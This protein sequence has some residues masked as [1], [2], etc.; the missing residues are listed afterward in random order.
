MEQ[1]NDA[2]R[3]RSAVGRAAAELASFGLSD[4]TAGAMR[5]AW[6]RF[7]AFSCAG[8]D[9]G[10]VADISAEVASAYVRARSEGGS[11]PSVAAMHWR[12]SA[13]RLLFR[14]W[15][16][17]GVCD[18]DPTLDLRLPRRSSLAARPLADDEVAMCRWAA[19][20]TATETRL[21]V[22]WALAETGATTG[23]IPSVLVGDVDLESGAVHLAGSTKTDPRSARLSEWGVSQVRRRIE[24]LDGRESV[25]L[26]YDGA[27][28]PASAQASVSGAIGDIFRRAGLG[29]EPDVRPRSVAAWLGR[30]IFDE[31]GRIE[32]VAQRLGL[33]S[34]DRAAALIGWEWRCE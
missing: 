19:L 24:A 2:A 16:E 12:R 4:Q 3:L 30:T 20:S 9:V 11:V 10:T 22:V 25:A 15:R 26:A 29:D 27:G 1:G 6:Y 23:E 32:L 17:L 13:L 34:L 5:K 7:A 14:V 28:G 18:F 31:T 33:R 21:P 8:D